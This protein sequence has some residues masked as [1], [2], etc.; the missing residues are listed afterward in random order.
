MR[1]RKKSQ[2]KNEIKILYFFM[3]IM[4]YKRNVYTYLLDIIKLSLSGGLHA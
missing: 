1:Q 2:P 3:Q 4:Y